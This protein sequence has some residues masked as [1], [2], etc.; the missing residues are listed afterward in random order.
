MHSTRSI[1]PNKV[2]RIGE[3]RANNI[4]HIRIYIYDTQLMLLSNVEIKRQQKE[5]H[6]TLCSV[7]DKRH[8]EQSFRLK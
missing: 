1:H 8:F 6:K 5:L 2:C 4:I 3:V 7:T